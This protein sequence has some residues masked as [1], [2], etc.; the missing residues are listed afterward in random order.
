MSDTVAELAERVASTEQRLETIEAR[1]DELQ[2]L[3]VKRGRSGSKATR[4]PEPWPLSDEMKRWFVANVAAK[5]PT[6]AV[7]AEH[8][9]FCDYW[10]GKAGQQATKRDWTATWR[11]W[12]RRAAHRWDSPV[13][14][15]LKQQGRQ[16]IAADPQKQGLKRYDD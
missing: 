13:G 9:A 7:E 8:E 12:M 16:P 3:L 11:N 1:L 5:V 6:R 14:A 10:R 15:Y 4:L 2:D